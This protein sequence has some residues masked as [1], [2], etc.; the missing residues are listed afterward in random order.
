MISYQADDIQDIYKLL[1]SKPDPDIMICGFDYNEYHIDNMVEDRN[2]DPPY[3]IAIDNIEAWVRREYPK[4]DRANVLKEL[5]S[6]INDREQ[7]F[8]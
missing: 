4:Q 6:K 7:G 1:D 3:Y 2:F 5:K 8:K